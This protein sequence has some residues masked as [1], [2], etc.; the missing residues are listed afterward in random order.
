MRSKPRNRVE[1][2][3]GVHELTEQCRRCHRTVPKT[4]NCF[5]HVVWLADQL[6]VIYYYCEGLTCEGLRYSSSGRWHKLCT[7]CR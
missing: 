4:P 1:V 3:Q 5:K 2:K 6:F 7:G